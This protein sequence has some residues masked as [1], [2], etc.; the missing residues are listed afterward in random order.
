MDLQTLLGEDYKDGMTVEEISTALA[1]KNIADLS[2]GGYVDVNKH[3]KQVNALKN[4][5][6]DLTKQISTTDEDDTASGTKPAKNT[7]SSEDA[8]LI[9]SLQEQIA[10]LTIENNKSGIVSQLSGVE[11]I[12][13]WGDDDTDYTEFVATVAGLNATQ[14]TS[15]MSFVTNKLKSV[16]ESGKQ[17]AL[18]N[19]MGAMGNSMGGN[20][21]SNAQKTQS[22]LGALGKK[23]A[24][25]RM[26][27]SNADYYFSRD[28]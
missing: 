2:L 4:K 12:P 25:A 1:S 13:K 27:N 6:A 23:L 21:Q 20:T 11:G 9:K 8:K 15:I 18:R 5:I 19:S 28:K 7:T 14:S 17:D 26:K 24:Q 22:D 10:N 16:Y 3:N